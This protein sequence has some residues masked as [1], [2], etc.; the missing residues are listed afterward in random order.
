MGSCPLPSG[1]IYYPLT[2][3]DEILCFVTSIQNGRVTLSDG[4]ITEF[5]TDAQ[6]GVLDCFAR[7][8]TNAEIADALKVELQ[9]VKNYITD[10]LHVLH[11]GSRL[12]AVM[13]ARRRG[14]L[15]W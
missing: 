15:G 14:W 5:L 4:G 9:T 3:Q 11:A 13:V 10:I 2:E 7:G 6:I 8:L 12:D 1:C